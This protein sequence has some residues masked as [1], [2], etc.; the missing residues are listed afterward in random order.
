MYCK[1]LFYMYICE[2]YYYEKISTCNDIVKL[3]I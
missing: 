2:K 1:V 3:I